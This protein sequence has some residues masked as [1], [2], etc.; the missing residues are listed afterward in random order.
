VCVCVCVCVLKYI[1]MYIAFFFLSPHV[2][3]LSFMYSRQSL[4]KQLNYGGRAGFH[5]SASTALVSIH[6]RVAFYS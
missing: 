6:I 5:E 4:T 1:N 3:S 2:L